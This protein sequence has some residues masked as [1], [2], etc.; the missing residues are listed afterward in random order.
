VSLTTEVEAN[1][2]FYLHFGYRLLGQAE[3]A[4]DFATWAFFR[5]DSA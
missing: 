4:P 3:V 2:P 5:P 1:V